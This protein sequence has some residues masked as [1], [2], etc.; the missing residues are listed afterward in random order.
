MNPKKIEVIIK[1]HQPSTVTEV[2]S[3]LGFCNYYRKF[4]YQYAQVAKP[5][6]K[7]VSRD[8]AKKTNSKIDWSPKCK[9]AFL[10]LKQICTSTPVLAYANYKKCFGAHTD[11]SELGLGAVLYQEREDGT[12]CVI[13]YSSCS[14]LNAEGRYHSSKLEFLAL[15]WAVCEHF[16]E[17]LYGRTFDVFTDNNPL[18]YVLTSTKL[19]ATIQWQM[20]SLANMTLRSFIR[21]VSKMWTQMH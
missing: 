11:A 6:Y 17:Y 12:M 7:L 19:D 21:A 20:A 2:R 13:T 9:E 14:I 16:H 15:K 10:K 18:T 8:N 3:F 4:M 1:W 5:L